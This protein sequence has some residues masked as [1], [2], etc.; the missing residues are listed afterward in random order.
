[1]WQLLRNNPLALVLAVLFHIGLIAFLIVGVDWRQ[2]PAGRTGDGVVIQARV[3][4]TRRAEQAAIEEKRAKNARQHRAEQQQRREREEQLREQA[5]RRA[6]AE[7]ARQAAIEKKRQREQA[8]KLEAERKKKARA[9]KQRKLE[10]ERKRKLEAEK[11]RQAEARAERKRKLKAEKQRKAEAER[12]RK[13]EIKRK[14]EAEKKR[15][16]EAERKRRAA[17]EKKRKA[18]A[19]RRAAEERA[20]QQALEAEI[21]GELSAREL[22]RYI[23][24]IQKHI[25]RSW[26]RPPGSTRG[27]QC[28]V[29]VRLVGN[30]TIVPGSV[31]VTRGSG[32]SAF[33]RSVVQAVYKADPLPVPDDELLRARF[34]ELELIFDPD[35][36]P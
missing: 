25:T 13:A 22:N 10:A 16:Q 4:D 6:E 33:D 1:M 35:K 18:E 34:N 26:I 20:M 12:K 29:T 15:K 24:L 3:V 17:A 9:E 14:A 19:A 8:R 30:G 23:G 7:K 2:K 28:R 27:L 21:A 36:S 31:R 5:R 11:K 32:N